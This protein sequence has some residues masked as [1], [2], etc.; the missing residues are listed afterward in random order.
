MKS[1]IKTFT[2]IF[3][4]FAAS[5]AQTGGTFDLSHNV[6]A[7]GGGSNSTGG[8]FRIEGTAGQNLAGTQSTGGNFSLRGGF[9]AFES[10]AP[11]AA[12]VGVSGRVTTADGRGI[13]NAR[14]L[15]SD[16]SGTIRM[17]T[18]GAFGHYRLN[19]VATGQ[20][21]ILSISA[22][23]FVFASPTR[24]ITVNDEMNGEDFTAEPLL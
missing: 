8:N 21:Y 15:L 23:R 12:F 13:R 10:A 19:G 9:W 1:F 17:A 7:S 16:G 5:A 11:T 14:I 3:A 6:I 24:V 20:T 4:M 18:S 22:K 2:L